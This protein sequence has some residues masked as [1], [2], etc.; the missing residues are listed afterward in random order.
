V[1][2]LCARA[3]EAGLIEREPSEV[4]QRVVYLRVTPE[5][6]RRLYA[7]IRAS[8]G[9]RRELREAFDRLT[10]TVRVAS[11]RSRR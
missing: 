5:G 11:R 4:D 8:D 6:E 3:E 2:E 9:D 10:E 7:V 1:T